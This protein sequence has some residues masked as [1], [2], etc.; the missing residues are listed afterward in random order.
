MSIPKGKLI[1]IGGAEDKGTE[2]ENGY[3]HSN[4]SLNFFGLAILKRFVEEVGGSNKKIEVI[5]T[6][7]SM[8][9]YQSSMA[10]RPIFGAILS[11]F[12]VNANQCR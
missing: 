1:S 5:T 9:L 11:Q 6:A 10:S 7:S 2:P 12:R 4:K 8:W 3:A